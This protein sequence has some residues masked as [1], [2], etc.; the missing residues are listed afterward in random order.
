MKIL[1][2][3]S[4]KR[5]LKNPR[6]GS[7]RQLIGQARALN[8][9]GHE[10]E[11]DNINW[12]MPDNLDEFDIVHMVNSNGPNGAHQAL[13]TLSHRQGIPVV[14]TPTF[15]PPKELAADVNNQK[16]NAMI[17]LH[18][19]TLIPWL[20]N[21]DMLT[22]NSEIEAQKLNEKID[23]MHYEVVPNAVNLEE[24]EAIEENPHE[25]PEEWGDYVICV[26]RVEP[27]KN[28]W[29][30]IYAMQGL[31]DKG[32]D[33]NLVL[34]GQVNPNYWQKLSSEVKRHGEK[35]YIEDELQKPITVMNAMKHADVVAMPS[36]IETPGL[37]ALEAGALD[38]PLAITDRGATKEYFGDDANYC[39]PQRVDSIAEALTS[40]WNQESSNCS[41]KVNKHYNYQIAASILE[42]TYKELIE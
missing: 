6:H 2:A 5:P 25:P 10:V 8:N 7:E 37:V 30:L 24:I 9:R 32:I 17:D 12:N 22:P 21:T 1:F 35:I 13:A 3:T 38:V 18:M 31:W 33:V 28:Q 41:E 40:A 19:K 16:N 36:F 39:N 29:R 42:R 27:R 26:G 14:G 15:W 11:I 23:P 20:A 4:T 34:I